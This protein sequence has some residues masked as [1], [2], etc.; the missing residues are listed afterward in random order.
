M[1]GDILNSPRCSYNNSYT[2]EEKEAL[3]GSIL[4]LG[5]TAIGI[6]D[7][8]PNP[9]DPAFDGVEIHATMIDNIVNK[10]FMQRPKSIFNL[11]L[12]ILLLIGVL[13]SPILIFSRATHAGILG[14]IFLV[15]YYYFD[16]FYWFNNGIWAYIGMPYIEIFSL[17]VSITLY[18]YI[19]EEKDKKFLKEAFGSYN[20][21]D[22]IHLAG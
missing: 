12:L 5:M 17:F 7:Q 20:A 8:R 15:G 19:T 18:K 4:L 16:K 11:E 21:N 2:D 1:K 22:V 10:D 13:F 14:V 9:F 6:N 3:K